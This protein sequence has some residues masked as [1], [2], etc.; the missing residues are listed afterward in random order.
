MGGWYAILIN[1]Y[2]LLLQSPMMTQADIP[3]DLSDTDKA[4]I[5]QT[6]DAQLNS[7]ILFALLHGEQ[8]HFVSSYIGTDQ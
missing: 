8:H 1:R 4:A 5:F 7:K 6:L 2:L 3:A